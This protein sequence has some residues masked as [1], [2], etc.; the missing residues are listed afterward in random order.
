MLR[1]EAG[2]ERGAVAVEMA[3][4]LPILL[5]CIAGIIDLGRL[6]FVQTMVTNAAREGARMKSLGYSNADTETRVQNASPTIAQ[7]GM[8]VSVSYP[9]VCPGAPL[10]TDEA[11]VTVTV[12]GFDWLILDGVMNLVGGSPAA[13]SPSSTA[14]MRCLG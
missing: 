12:T 3:L 14:S 7:Q 8:G 5:L 6:F 4:V 1:R 2:R 10:P 11:R 9:L 13:P